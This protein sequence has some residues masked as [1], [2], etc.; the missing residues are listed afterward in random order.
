MPLL[1]RL[2]SLWR[3]LFHKA[4]REQ[5]LTEEIDAYLEMLIE[6]KIEQGLDPR[7]ARRAALIELGGKQHVKERI[8]E[9]RAGHLLGTLSQDLRYALRMLRR[10][11]GFTAVVVLILALGLGANTAIFTL[12]NVA[13]LKSLPVSRPDELVMLITNTRGTS[14]NQGSFSHALWEQIR[15]RQ[16]IFTAVSVYGSTGVDLDAG[17]E[18]RSAALGLVSSDFFSVLGVRMALGRTIADADDQPGCSS[19]AVITHAYWQSEFGGSADVIGKSIAVSG[20]PFQIVGVTEPAFF[21]IQ[22]GYYTPIW[23]PHCAGT[24]IRGAGAYSGGGWVIGRLKPGFTLEQTR[25]RLA[26]LA[27]AI[28]DATVPANA[29]A[30][31]AAQ[32]RKSTFDVYPFAKG[33]PGL[34]RSYGAVLFLLMAIVGVVLLIA[35]ANIANLLLARAT[36]RQH[37]IAVRLALGASRFRLFRQLLTESLLLSL[38]GAALSVLFAGWGSRFLVGFLAGQD[39]IVPLD[40]TP[41]LN[42]LG[43]TLAVGIL[44]G[45]LFG[46]APAWRAA[47]IDPYTVMKPSSF[48]VAAGHSRF[49][50]GKALVVAQITLSL[51]MIVGAGLLLNSWRRLVTLDPG[52]KSAGVLLAGIDTRPA[53]IPVNQ[54]GATYSRILERLRAIPGVASASAA[55]LTPFGSVNSHITIKVEGFSSLSEND[56]RVRFNQVSDRYFETIGTRLIAGRDFN[57]G[58]VATS[59]KVVIVSEELARKFYGGARALGQRIR[60]QQ[61]RDLSPPD[62]IIGIAANIKE[63]SLGEASQPTAY[64]PLSQ[65]THPW[66]GI[67]FALRTETAPSAIIPGVK[68]AIAEIGPRFSLNIR[69]LQQQVDGSV[70]LSRSLAMLSGFFGGLALLLAA[71]GLYGIIAYSVE[72]RRNEIGVR[73]ALGATRRRIVRMVLGEVGRL[74]VTGVALGG[75]LSFVLTRLATRFLF[76]MESNEMATLAL[77]ALTLTAVALGAALLPAWRA[78][79]LDPMVALRDE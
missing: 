70:R 45:V 17:G 34:S 9:V 44:T 10:S 74:V 22:Y 66:P 11:P 40:L 53:R 75:L 47:H 15:D 58:D 6:Q 41:D 2:S 23:A 5:E 63:I 67:N 28:L 36:A 19:V 30:E 4:R 21:G 72:R 29:T 65:I 68:A 27:P 7:E 73:I 33:L 57:S 62:E 79:R 51:V 8:R 14:K 1:P 42:V 48:G 24:I 55:G 43:F 39:R 69:T 50:L 32:Y 37:E 20:Q 3:N 26:A 12:I 16:D 77:A 46:L 59:P 56:A 76:G 38:L 35:C 13:M 71:I 49:S 31:A 61:G 54:L 78:A 64:Y 25:A 52:F 18:A 60:V